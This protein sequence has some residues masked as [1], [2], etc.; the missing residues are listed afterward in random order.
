MATNNVRW[1]ED[2]GWH[3]L[4]V[5]GHVMAAFKRQSLQDTKLDRWFVVFLVSNISNEVLPHADYTEAQVKQLVEMKYFLLRG[6]E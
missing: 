5:D 3:D 4:E 2:E 1:V 6:D